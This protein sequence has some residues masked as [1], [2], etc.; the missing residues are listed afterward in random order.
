MRGEEY[1]QRR[2]SRLMTQEEVSRKSGV[3][4]IVINHYELGK[5]NPPAQILGL[6]IKALEVNR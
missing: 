4:K 3:P 5:L 2:V 6:L 1:R